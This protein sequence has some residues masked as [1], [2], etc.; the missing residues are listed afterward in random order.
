[1][2]SQFQYYIYCSVDVLYLNERQNNFILTFSTVHFCFL[3]CLATISLKVFALFDSFL[4]SFSSC[5]QETQAGG[6]ADSIELGSCGIY[7]TGELFFFITTRMS[8][9]R[10]WLDPFFFGCGGLRCWCDHF[11]Q[12]AGLISGHY[13]L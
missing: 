2:K 8:R 5:A 4:L 12:C 11:F 10:F 1:M 13:F 9:F 6:T 3:R 7:V